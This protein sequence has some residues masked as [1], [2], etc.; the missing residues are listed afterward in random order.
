MQL[1]LNRA[2]CASTALAT[3]LLIAT[4]AFAQSTGSATIEELVVTGASGPKSM[5]GIL[6]QVAPKTK[7]TID[8][9]FIARQMP[10]QTI[11]ETL[12]VVPGYN[13]TNNDP[14]GNPGGNIRLR[15]FDGARISLQ[16]D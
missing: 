1:R 7:T 11:A 8:Q 15:S 9:Q 4:G 6:A 5:D 3:G 12:N 13:F 10:G 2:L 14:Y 16:W